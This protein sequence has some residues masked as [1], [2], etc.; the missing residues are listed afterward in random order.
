MK[1]TLIFI[2]TFIIT[3]F[4]Y[5]FASSPIGEYVAFGESPAY[6]EISIFEVVEAPSDFEF[7]GSEDDEDQETKTVKKSDS[8]LTDSHKEL[9]TFI[10]NYSPIISQKLWNLTQIQILNT[11]SDLN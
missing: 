9:K 4:F 3:K 1:Y 5:G 10:T 6:E 11:S 7:G 8:F 2:I